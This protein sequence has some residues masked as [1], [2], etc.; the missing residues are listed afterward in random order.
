[1]RRRTHNFRL[2]LEVNLA[3][4]RILTPPPG[5][6]GL[7]TVWK[8]TAFTTRGCAGRALKDAAKREGDPL[9][10]PSNR[11]RLQVAKREYIPCI[12]SRA[13]LVSGGSIGVCLRPQQLLNE[14]LSSALCTGINS[15]VFRL[16]RKAPPDLQ[17]S[18]HIHTTIY[19]GVLVI[20]RSSN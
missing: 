3:F 9:G 19:Y 17:E 1:M 18:R 8:F 12:F 5:F 13:A 11:R 14:L 20:K 10:P 7:T 15:R 16:G 2:S 6:Q 4:L